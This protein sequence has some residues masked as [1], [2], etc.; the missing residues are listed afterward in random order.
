MKV[1]YHHIQKTAG[2]SFRLWLW[3]KLGREDVFWQGVDGSFNDKDNKKL[4][5][6]GIKIYGGLLS[7]KAQNN[8]LKDV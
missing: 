3:E 2:T 4:K 5:S 7:L 8:Q 6:K 1:F